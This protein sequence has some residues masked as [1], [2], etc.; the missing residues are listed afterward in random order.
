MNLSKTPGADGPVREKSEISRRS[1]FHRATVAGAAGAAGFYGLFN[2]SNAFG[3]E[4][5]ENGD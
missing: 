3:D 4:P 1:F 2:I 5:Q